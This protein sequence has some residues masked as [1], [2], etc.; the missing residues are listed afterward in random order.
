[1]E[2]KIATALQARCDALQLGVEILD[3]GV[4]L[5]DVHPPLE[6]VSAFRDV[7]MAFKEK[8]RMLNEADASYRDKVIK[9]G[10]EEAWRQLSAG[11]GAL[12]DKLWEQLQPQ[13]AGEAAAEL[14]SSQ[15]FATEQQERAAGEAASF[16]LQQAAHARSPQLTAWRLFLDSLA[17]ALPGKKKLVLDKQG[18]GRR[19]LFLGVPGMNAVQPFTGFSNPAGPPVEE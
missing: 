19:Q 13:I 17:A 16:I 2:S 14:F 1:L 12:T 11:D 6:V 5:Q 3:Q 9:A 7:S 8:E 10:G 18:N 4:C 15:A